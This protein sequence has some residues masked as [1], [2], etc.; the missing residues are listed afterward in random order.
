LPIPSPPKQILRVIVIVIL[1]L[2][3]MALLVGVPLPWR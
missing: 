3:L 1:V 2:Y